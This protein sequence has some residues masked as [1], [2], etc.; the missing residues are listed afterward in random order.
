MNFR[1][2][3][4]YNMSERVTP[5]GLSLPDAHK[6]ER[7]KVMRWAQDTLRAMRV[8]S[9]SAS[10]RV[11]GQQGSQR[12]NNF[13]P[14]SLSAARR[15]I[16]L[17]F[18]VGCKC[19]L[20]AIQGGKLAGMCKV[21]VLTVS[22]P[23]VASQLRA[24]GINPNNHRILQCIVKAYTKPASALPPPFVPLL[25][26]AAALGGVC[27]G[28]YVFVLS[29]LPLLRADGR[30]PWPMVLPAKKRDEVI[31]PP[32]SP[33]T[34]YLPV[35]NTFTMEGC[36]D[37]AIPTYDDL[38]AS[39]SHAAV[40]P[41]LAWDLRKSVAVFRGT[42]TGCGTHVRTNPRLAI[43]ELRGV[44]GLDAGVVT[45]GKAMRFDPERGL[46][47][48]SLVP[49]GIKRF[50]K[51]SDVAKHK[52]VVHI[53]GN[54]A[55][56][57]LAGMLRLGC[58]QM[59]VQGPYR[60]WYSPMV[61]PGINAVCVKRDLSDLAAMIMWCRRHD[62]EC[63]DM[64]AQGQKLGERLR[65]A[66]VLVRFMNAAFVAAVHDPVYNPGAV[67]ERCLKPPG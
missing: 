4:E 66:A 61:L 21:D 6:R 8:S 38:E 16:D 42:S 1:S 14:R 30:H 39:E 18:R 41:G 65:S 2:S 50:M 64:A 51:P 52:Y 35:F 7:E 15:T 23:V 5:S 59:I 19:S 36:L 20:V 9:S 29:D 47:Q 57:R 10:M 55:A 27:D 33:R 13:D 43:S 53:E 37:I 54:V 34:R 40:A 25:A 48:P 11:S 58:L 67:L 17:A 22:D 31:A 24:K 60:L 3:A 32:P 26:A 44:P 63:R 12:S 49:G 56:Y 45:L 28:L 46:G 62:R